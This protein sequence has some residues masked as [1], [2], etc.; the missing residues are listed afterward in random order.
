MLEGLAAA[1][2]V[3]WR[4]LHSFILIALGL[5]P[6]ALS[7]GFLPALGS[8]I[9]RGRLGGPRGMPRFEPP[10]LCVWGRRLPR[11]VSGP[12]STSRTSATRERRA[13]S[14]PDEGCCPPRSQAFRGEGENVSPRIPVSTPPPAELAVEGHKPLKTPTRAGPACGTESGR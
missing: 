10:T 3:R 8:E 9:A 1:F 12:G 6:A 13:A 14:A 4:G 7:E 11:A 2:G 5:T